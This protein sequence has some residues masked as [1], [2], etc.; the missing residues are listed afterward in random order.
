MPGGHD[1]QPG[2]VGERDLAALA[3]SSVERVARQEPVAVEVEVVRERR[4]LRGFLGSVLVPQL[5]ID[6]FTFTGVTEP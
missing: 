6:A 3:R 1:A 2:E 4:Q 5:R